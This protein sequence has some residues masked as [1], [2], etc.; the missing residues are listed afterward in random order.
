MNKVF[1][2]FHTLIFTEKSNEKNQCIHNKI[3]SI[4]IDMGRDACWVWF[5]FKALN[6]TALV[7]IGDMVVT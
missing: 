5:P 4:P 6:P 1:C 3:A 7:V 2:E